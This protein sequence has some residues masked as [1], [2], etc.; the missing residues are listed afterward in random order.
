MTANGPSHG[1][2]PDGA[3]TTF[4]P[5]L[6]RLGTQNSQSWSAV[7]AKRQ[8]AHSVHIEHLFVSLSSGRC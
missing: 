4:T 7:A 1:Q 6:N 3:P 5:R 2:K 8:L